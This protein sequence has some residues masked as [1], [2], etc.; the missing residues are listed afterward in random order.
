MEANQ[1]AFKSSFE[2]VEKELASEKLEFQKYR[3]KAHAALQQSSTIDLQSKIV[4]L[5]R[6]RTQ[7]EL[8]ISEKQAHLDNAIAR[9]E[10][11]QDDLKRTMQ[12]MESLEALLRQAEATA[13]EA[14]DLRVELGKLR[15]TIN[16][17]TSRIAELEQNEA[18]LI[19]AKAAIESDLRA[20]GDESNGMLATVEN[21]SKELEVQRDNLSKALRDLDEMRARQEVLLTQGVMTVEPAPRHSISSASGTFAPSD[22]P[23]SPRIR[24]SPN[25]C[26]T[27]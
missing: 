1:T 25:P 18:T 5:E 4:E 21:L 3:I 2:R 13:G 27:F 20:K 7:L 24:P 26:E 15:S 12:R 14:V 16:S 19:I 11:S 9:A 8:I 10:S 17:Q 22:T 23:T 6:A